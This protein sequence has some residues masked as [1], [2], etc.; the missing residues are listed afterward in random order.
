MSQ[1]ITPIVGPPTMEN[2]NTSDTF[3]YFGFGS[4]MLIQRLQMG[5]PSAK[6]FAVGKLLN[7][8]LSFMNIEGSTKSSWKGAAATI[9]ESRGSYVYGVVYEIS[10]KEQKNLDIQELV[11]VGRY[12]RIEVEVLVDDGVPL[13]CWCYQICHPQAVIGAPSP[14]YKDV[15]V[16]GAVQN[17]LPHDYLTFLHNIEDNKYDGE[18]ELYDTVMKFY[19]D[20]Q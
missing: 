6:K 11:A 17:N 7:Y 9:V 12:H 14:Q 5:S 3:Y 16:R 20:N 13:K 8:K 18:C 15:I 19:A 2:V 1:T 4:N 10:L